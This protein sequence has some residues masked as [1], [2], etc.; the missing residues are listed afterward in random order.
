MGRATAA[1]SVANVQSQPATGNSSA[2]A[3]KT[4]ADDEDEVPN[5]D[6]ASDYKLVLCV[7]HDLKMKKGKVA[8]QCSHAAVAAYKR[9]KR[10][11]PT[12][13]REWEMDGQPKITVKLPGEED[14][15][16]VVAEAH[17]AGLAVSVIRDAG[18]TQVAPGTQT[19]AAIGPGPVQVVDQV[20]RRFK[21]Y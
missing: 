8:A 1:R 10:M 19:V 7:R 6:E 2:E 20:T 9:M 5:E 4:D 16:T 15:K 13:L 12:V 17:A 11:N 3:T 21:L 14:M 18:R